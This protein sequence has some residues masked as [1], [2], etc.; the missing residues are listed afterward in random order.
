MR[1]CL[2]TSRT[3]RGLYGV[4]LCLLRKAFALVALAFTFA[5][6]GEQRFPP[7]EFESGYKLPVAQTPLPRTIVMQYLDVGVLLGA[8]ALASYLVLKKRSRNGVLALSIFSLAYFGFYR[9]GCVCAIG[10]IQNVATALFDSS[11]AVPIAVTLFFIAPLA[12]A[13]FAGRT[14]CAAVCPHG[15][16]QDLMLLKPLK[17]P[18]WLEQGL[19]VMPF[20]YLGAAVLFAATGSAFV[21]CEYDPFVPLFRL[22]GSHG[23]LLLGAAFLLLATVVGRPYCRFLCPYGALLR[24]AGSVS[25]WRVTVTPDSC[26]RCRLCEESCPFGAIEEPTSAQGQWEALRGERKRLAGFVFL[27]PVLVLLGGWIGSQLSLAASQLS[28]TVALAERFTAPSAARIDL[29]L[30][31]AESLSM[32][33]AEQNAKELLENALSVRRKFQ[34]GGWWLG[35]WIGLVVA[36]KLIG[37]S[38]RRNRTN[39]EPNRASCFACARCFSSCPNER[40]RL[41]LAPLVLPA[42]NP[43][44]QSMNL[45]SQI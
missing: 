21:I 38:V 17:V 16:I 2:Q 14:F 24:L 35:G 15:A 13:L 31:T 39:Y 41:G 30:Q 1:R 43:E 33:R 18:S 36:V 27:L 40:S 26:T 23:M 25:K 22:S 19:G 12:V 8:L 42:Q 29:S 37:L 44:P 32:R 7:P 28:P 5:A 3:T 10:S 11:Y 6:F 20:V 34:T 9:K 4:G 45:K